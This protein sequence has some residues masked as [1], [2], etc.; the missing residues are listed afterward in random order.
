MSDEKVCKGYPTKLSRKLRKELEKLPGLYHPN[1]HITLGNII[2]RSNL[3]YTFNANWIIRGNPIDVIVKV[4]P[5]Y[6]VHI[7]GSGKGKRRV[8]KTWFATSNE[9]DILENASG[10]G[11]P[12][13]PRLLKSFTENNFHYI[14]YEKIEGLTLRQYRQTYNIKDGSD[15]YFNTNRLNKELPDLIETFHRD[16]NYIHRNITPDNIIVGENSRL[17]LIDFENCVSFTS[18][19]NHVSNPPDLN[20]TSVRMM[21]GESPMY[22]DDF[23]SLVYTMYY[24][25]YNTL[26]WLNKSS[27]RKILKLKREFLKDL[28]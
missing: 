9:C 17:Y 13:L 7:P 14:V 1:Y 22:G 15:G 23:E 18:S 12:Y 6:S 11:K 2:H 16:F 20:F 27:R 5:I 4:T 26:P 8:V 24:F 21:E 28:D 3:V 25:N 10:V 19:L